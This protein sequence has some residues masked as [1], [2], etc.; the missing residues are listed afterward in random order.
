MES[1][2]EQF[3]SLISES[4]DELPDQLQHV[5]NLAII[6]E[7]EPDQSQRNRLHLFDGQLLFGLYEGVPLPARGGR[8]PMIPDKITLFKKPIE[9]I[10]TN[11]SE[12]KAQIKH[13]LWHE[14]GHYYGLDHG[15]IHKL[16]Q[17]GH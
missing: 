13:T 9:H 11:M 1:T 16:E 7:E 17:K 4:M 14:L 2:L 5:E 8:S 12:L 3:E 15:M 10:C 6:V